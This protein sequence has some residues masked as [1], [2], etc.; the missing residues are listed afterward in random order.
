[1]GYQS[2][3]PSFASAI[4]KYTPKLTDDFVIEYMVDNHIMAKD[5]LHKT[6]LLEL[7]RRDLKNNQIK[8]KAIVPEVDEVKKAYFDNEKFDELAKDYPGIVKLKDQLGL[9]FGA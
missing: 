6:N 3:S 7:I 9:D 4:A 2:K 1:M 8:L 5:L